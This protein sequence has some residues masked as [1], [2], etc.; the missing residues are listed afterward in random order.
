MPSLGVRHALGEEREGRVGRTEATTRRDT[1]VKTRQEFF[2]EV[3]ANPITVA[4][5]NPP[6]CVLNNVPI[7]LPPP[8]F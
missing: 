4:I 7:I 8:M 2:A 1:R 5:N 3:A 6:S